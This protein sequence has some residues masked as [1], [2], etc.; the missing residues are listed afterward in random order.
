VIEVRIHGRGGQGAVIASLVIANAA[1]RKGYHVQVFPE[2]GVERR[3]VPVTAFARIDTRPILLRTRIQRP[4]HVIVLD[5][6]IAK[7]LPVAA[8]LE[9]GGS[10]VMNAKGPEALDSFQNGWKL[11]WV[12]GTSIAAKH[13]IGTATAPIVNTAIVG[14]FAAVTKLFEMD[15]VKGAMKELFPKAVD[16]N[17]QAAQEAFEGVQILPSPITEAIGRL[18]EGGS[19]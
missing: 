6:A 14:A 1:Y 5:P 11:A 17:F 12:D 8:G 7:Y 3:G 4:D 9:Q 2:F 10:I 13:K 15:H 18:Y 19:R 16:R